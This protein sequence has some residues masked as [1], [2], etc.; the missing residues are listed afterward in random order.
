MKRVNNIYSKICDV[1]NIMEFEYIISVNTKNKN[2]VERFQQ[3]YVQNIYKIREKLITK[4]YEP[5]EYSIF[6]I[7]EPN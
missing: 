2:K 7:H 4:S 3:Y 5:S 6:F 1:D